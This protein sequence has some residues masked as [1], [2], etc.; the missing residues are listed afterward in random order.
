[1]VLAS[2][3]TVVHKFGNVFLMEAG[4]SERAKVKEGGKVLHE[5]VSTM[6]LTILL[7]FSW[8]LKASYMGRE[9]V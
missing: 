1:M 2:L 3:N 5:I 6:C 8:A 7:I 4:K 9:R